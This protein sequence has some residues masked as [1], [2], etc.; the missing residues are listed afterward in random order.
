M[1]EWRRATL[2]AVVLLI[3]ALGAGCGEKSEDVSGTPERS[4]LDLTLDWFANP[5][6]VAFYEALSQG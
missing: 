3:A 5:D 2:A 6:L 1:S 4:Q